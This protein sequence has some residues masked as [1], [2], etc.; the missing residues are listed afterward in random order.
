MS[1]LVDLLVTHRDHG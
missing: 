1:A